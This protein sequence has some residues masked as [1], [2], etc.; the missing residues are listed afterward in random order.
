MNAAASVSHRAPSN[1]SADIVIVGGGA[2][3][4]VLASRLSENPDLHVLL[5]E[6]G[7]DT[8]VDATPDDIADIFPRAYANPEYFWPSL[9]AVQRNGQ[10]AV[11]FSQAR[12]LGGGSSVMGMWAL[13]G[14]PADYD[15]W[16]AAGAVGWSYQDVLPFFKKLERDLNFPGGEHGDRGPIPIMRRPRSTW[17]AFA[18]AFAK[19]AEKRG[20]VFSPDLNAED[21]DGVFEMPFSN[22]GNVRASSASAYLTAEVRRR[23]NLGILTNTE[24]TAL[25]MDGRRVVGV[26][27]R[28]SDASVFDIAAARVV[29][30]AGAIYSPTL[31]LRSGIG[32]GGELSALGI[33]PVVDNPGV[34]KN[35]QN[36]AFIHLGAVVRRE[37]RH[38]PALRSYA[39]GCVRASSKHEGA[40]PSDMF[41]SI[42]SRS[43]PRDRDTSLGMIAV[44]LYSPFSRGS[45]TLREKDG[46]PAV[47]L[48]LLEDARDRSRLVTAAKMAR[49]LINDD[50]VRSTT[51]ESFLLPSKLPI[52]LLSQPGMKSDLFSLA[53]ARLLDINGW[54]RRL[55][56]EFG[57]GK[58]RALAD[59]TDEK[60]FEELVIS[61]A[62]SMFHPAGTC[63][64][65]VVVDSSTA[66]KGVDG[67]FV[68]DA[69]IMPKVPRA[70][71]NI[72]TVMV[73]EKAASEILKKIRNG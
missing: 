50:L 17:P 45:V 67:L 46:G 51:F 73:A 3:G 29:V 39:L 61:S 8:P 13:R 12:V 65:G 9:Q 41:M 36:H 68:A 40:P 63:A 47:H 38:N 19:A 66:V 25:K 48:G 15:A 10:A 11:P 7:R 28:R 69:S 31:L 6:A 58:G 16:S 30:S 32:P 14:L 27:G 57:I 70:N 71:T 37:A 42:L 56:L 21:T 54:V 62:T 53:L 26:S 52:R 20:F 59:L 55:T 33:E 1:L 2:S 64:L 24:I 43:G 35:L 44:A 72:P 60:A 23:P 5:I 18:E 34:G 4:C 22:D 49:D